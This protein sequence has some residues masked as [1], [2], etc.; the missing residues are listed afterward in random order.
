MGRFATKPL[1]KSPASSF[2]TRPKLFLPSRAPPAPSP[3]R[4]SLKSLRTKPPASP[5]FLP[6]NKRSTRRWPRPLLVTPFVSPAGG[7]WSDSCATMEAA[8][9]SR[10]ALKKAVKYRPH[11]KPNLKHAKHARGIGARESSGSQRRQS[12]GRHHYGLHFRLG[13]HGARIEHAQRPWCS[14]RNAGRL[15]SPHSRLA[16]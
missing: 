16:F 14:P 11:E 3:R 13:D 8:R 10:R 15:G 5:A 12:F 2:L 1:T 7:I 9:A 6:P 4:V